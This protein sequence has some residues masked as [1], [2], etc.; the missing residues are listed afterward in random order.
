MRISCSGL[1]AVRDEGRRGRRSSYFQRDLFGGDGRGEGGD[2]G[3]QGR[4]GERGCEGGGAEV[5]VRPQF[6]GVLGSWVKVYYM[7]YVI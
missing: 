5:L 2:G 7:Q 1:G 6:G 3:E 4:D